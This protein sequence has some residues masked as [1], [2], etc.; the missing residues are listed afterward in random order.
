MECL[1][2]TK[3][4]VGPILLY[5]SIGSANICTCLV[6]SLFDSCDPMDCSPQA[7]LSMGFPRKEYWSELLVP[8]LGDSSDP[9]IEPVS[10]ALACKFF[11]T[12]P[13]EKP[14]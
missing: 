4:L 9:G 8:S 2:N 10:H 6:T 11:T 7:P 3:A 14:Q 12:E 5:L 1:P 13:L